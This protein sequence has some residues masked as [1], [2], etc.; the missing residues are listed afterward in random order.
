VGVRVDALAGREPFQSAALTEDQIHTLAAAMEAHAPGTPYGLMVLFMAY[1]GLRAGE[2]AG[3]N[4]GD[5]LLPRGVIHV[6]SIRVK[7][8][9]NGDR[10]WRVN[11]PKNNKVRRVP[12]LVPWLRDDLAAYLA[13]HPH[14]GNPDA[15]LWPGSTSTRILTTKAERGNKRATASWSSVPDYD[16]PWDRDPFYKRQFKP[17][18]ELAGLPPLRLH[19]LRHTAGSLM[20]SKGVPDYRVAEYL[21]HSVDVLRKIYTHLLDPDVDADMALFAA[22]PRPVL[23]AQ[24][25][26]EVTPLRRAAIVTR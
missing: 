16:K 25:A 20:L 15:P 3:L 2:V 22:S 1:T 7:G 8:K 17:A 13:Q 18:V 5:V 4:I 19:D 12:I 10:G 9:G 23:A 6:R 11:R 14:R 24:A 26:C 21:G